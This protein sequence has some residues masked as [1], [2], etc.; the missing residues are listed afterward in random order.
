M[1]VVGLLAGLGGCDEADIAD[2]DISLRSVDAQ[3]DDDGN[4]DLDGGT[5]IDCP[6]CGSHWTMTDSTIE[7]FL[8]KDLALAAMDIADGGVFYHRGWKTEF[9]FLESLIPVE[10]GFVVMMPRTWRKLDEGELAPEAARDRFGVMR[11]VHG[12]AQIDIRL[13]YRAPGSGGGGVGDP[14]SE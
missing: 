11:L 14:V 9:S 12:T 10:G 1:C 7:V 13:E 2:G 6:K 8:E 3:I 5:I 4:G